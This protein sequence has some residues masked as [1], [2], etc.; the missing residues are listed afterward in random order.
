MSSSSNT[1]AAVTVGTWNLLDKDHGVEAAESFMLLQPYGGLEESTF[2]PDKR[3]LV[4]AEAYKTGGKY[5]CKS[6]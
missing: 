2:E 6:S 3:A 4:P 5:R 1:G